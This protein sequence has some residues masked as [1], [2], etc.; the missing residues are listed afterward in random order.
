MNPSTLA[1]LGLGQ[2]RHDVSLQVH[3]SCPVFNL[4]HHIIIEGLL[5][6][7]C[8]Q[9]RAMP[10]LLGETAQNLEDRFAR[11]LGEIVRGH[12]RERL[13]HTL[14]R[15]LHHLL[16]QHVQKLLELLPGLGSHEVVISQTADGPWRIIWQGVELLQAALGHRLQQPQQIR[17]RRLAVIATFR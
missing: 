5:K 9:K 8:S 17:V 14:K 12:L 15:L 2:T 3:R 10:V 6:G 7:G 1:G 16:L 13:L 11:D 4:L